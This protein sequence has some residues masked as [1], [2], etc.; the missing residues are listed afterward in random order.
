MGFESKS[1]HV[2]CTLPPSRR[3]VHIVDIDA[4]VVKV[5]VHAIDAGRCDGVH[6]TGVL[7][8]KKDS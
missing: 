7:C 6:H 4:V 8:R 1:E 2:K 5:R 3:L